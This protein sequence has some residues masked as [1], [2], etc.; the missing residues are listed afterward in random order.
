M[1]LNNGMTQYGIH[2][3][4]TQKGFPVGLNSVGAFVDKYFE[5]F[6]GIFK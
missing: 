6:A 5:E 4:L 2:H 3:L 1:N